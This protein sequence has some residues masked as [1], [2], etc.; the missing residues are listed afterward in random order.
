MDLIHVIGTEDAL[1]HK[2]SLTVE[3]LN[4]IV[5]TV[6]LGERAE[7]LLCVLTQFIG[8]VGEV[9]IGT[10]VFDSE[11]DLDACLQAV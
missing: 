4:V 8:I 3:D 11:D 2:L 9:G 7:A 1:R 10:Q 6:L 5:P